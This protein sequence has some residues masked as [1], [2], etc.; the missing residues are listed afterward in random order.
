MKRRCAHP[1]DKEY[2]RYGARGIFVC[3]EWLEYPAY[4]DWCAK[5]FEVGKTIDRI[6]N[7]GPYSPG[8]CRWATP[9]EQQDNA[10]KT[11]NKTR[12]IRRAKVHQ[13]KWLHEKYGKIQ[14]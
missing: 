2:V 9:Q 8:N 5:T 1:D 4:H 3:K 14:R 6:N 12:S 10:R 11:V 7:D 13:M